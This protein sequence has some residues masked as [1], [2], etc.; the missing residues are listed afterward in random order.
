M[1]M[2]SFYADD[3]Y[4]TFFDL[5]EWVNSHLDWEMES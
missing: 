2:D 3:T 5:I 1:S 4:D